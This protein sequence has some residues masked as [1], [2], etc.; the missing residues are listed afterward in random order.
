MTKPAKVFTVGQILL[1]VGVGGGF[2]SAMVGLPHAFHKLGVAPAGPAAAH[3]ITNQLHV[4]F[5]CSGIGF[6]VAFIG[7]CLALGGAVA[8][9]LQKPTV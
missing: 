9:F 8:I 2:G 1:A 6:A 3:G 4:T 7:L 5:L